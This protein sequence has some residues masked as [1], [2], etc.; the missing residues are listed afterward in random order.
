MKINSHNE[1]DTVKEVVV[2][3]PKPMA[4][5]MF[6]KDISKKNVET[7]L[8]LAHRAWPEKLR[9]EV[10]EDLEELCDIIKDFGAKVLRPNAANVDKVFSTPDWMAIGCDCGNMRDLHLIVGNR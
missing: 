9:N 4:S 10:S 7:A 5:L 3:L 8:D 6:P 1:W 2:G